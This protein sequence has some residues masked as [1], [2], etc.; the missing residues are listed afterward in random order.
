[1]IGEGLVEAALEAEAFF[2]QSSSLTGLV[3]ALRRLAQL[4]PSTLA[5]MHGSSFAGDGSAMLED[6]ASG[7]E[8]RFNDLSFATDRPG[9]ADL[10][11]A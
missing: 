6:L 9:L 2:R 11:K 8:Q 5:I 4:R 10:Q 3:T 1:V 7:F